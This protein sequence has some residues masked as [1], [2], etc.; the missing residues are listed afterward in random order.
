LIGTGRIA[1]AYLASLASVAGVELIAVCD[2]EPALVA[3]S[4]EAFGCSPYTDHRAM[5]AT[6]GL[7][8]VVIATP[9]SSHR[10]IA[11]DAFGQGAHVL[12]EKPVAIS[13]DDIR[14]MQLCA[15][16]HGRSLMMASKFRYVED[17][18]K[19]RSLVQAGILG[20]PVRF[21]NTFASWVDVRQRW[22]SRK[23]IA[24]GGVLMDTGTHSVDIA[25]FLVGSITDV[26][27]FHGP[28]VQA[29]EVED[30]SQLSFRSAGGAT[31]TIDVSWSIHKETPAYVEIW[32]TEGMLSLG[33]SESRYRQNHEVAWVNFGHGYDRDAAFRDQLGNFVMSCTGQE[34]PRISAED[35]LAS[36]LV[37][38]AAYT[39]A[40]DGCWHKVP[41]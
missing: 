35:A 12:C 29:I 31:G 33:W 6:E 23:D 39:S 1:Q 40:N 26:S 18:S 7:D 13:S 34:A 16:E 4:A 19:A 27:A 37:I 5:L 28:K 38:E 32:G 21:E 2:T 8:G 20:A 3:A 22:N 41:Q 15:R 11:L 9:P 10:E 17:V 24:G 36:V 25:R 30:T 14:E